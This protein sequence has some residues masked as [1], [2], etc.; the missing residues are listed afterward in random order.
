MHK[1]NRLV[2]LGLVAAAFAV[3]L[4]SKLGCAAPITYSINQT[5]WNLGGVVSGEFEGEDLNQNGHL[6]LAAGEITRYEINFSGG[7]SIPA[8]THTLNDLL[9]FDYTLGSGGFRPSFPLYSLGSGYSYDADDYIIASPE[10]WSTPGSPSYTWTAS[11]AKVSN[12]A[13]VSRIP[14]PETLALV[15]PGLLFLAYARSGAGN[16]Q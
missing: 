10:F 9:Y 8:F 16:K 12:D 4:S 3:A 15:V 2:S 6:E 14:A 13:M 7:L 11:N 1:T 5:G